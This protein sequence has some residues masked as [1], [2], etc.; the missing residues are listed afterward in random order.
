[1]IDSNT[2]KPMPAMS[3]QATVKNLLVIRPRDIYGNQVIGEKDLIFDAE[4]FDGINTVKSIAVSPLFF[5][6]KCL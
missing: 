3:L 6:F 2:R 5:R 1:M 4:I